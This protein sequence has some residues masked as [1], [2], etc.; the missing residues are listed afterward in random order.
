MKFKPNEI[1][2]KYPDIEDIAIRLD[3]SEKET[4]EKNRNRGNNTNLSEEG[5]AS[6]R[7][8]TFQYTAEH[9]IISQFYKDGSWEQT[10]CTAK[11]GR[12]NFLKDLAKLL[13][14]RNPDAI[15]IEIF[16]GK[17]CK[18]GAV[19]TKD[20][21]LSETGAQKGTNAGE[22]SAELGSLVKK[23]DEKLTETKE[24][25]DA[26]NLK[27]ELLRKDF[28]A[29]IKENE[30]KSAIKDLGNEHQKE[31]NALQATIKEKDKYIE[32]LEADLNEYEGELSGFE[33]ESR[34]E[35]ALPF[36]ALIFSRVLVQAGENLLKQNPKILKIG[37]GLSEDEVKKIFETDAKKIESGQAAND[38]SSFSETTSEGD[39][40]GLDEKHA[41]GIKEMVDFFK[42]VSVTEFK[43]LYT[44]D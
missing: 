8:K 30:H 44:I 40:A 11:S 5:G 22:Q 28:D 14:T 29:Q 41:E 2:K 13:E 18:G 3:E 42:Q 35:K 27:I 10:P 26:S 6:K 36:S 17:T 15:K 9:E 37:L 32:E 21:Y 31:I 25:P 43:K 16:K 38:S 4:K 24:S 39:Y 34:K 19:Y 12:E 7:K 33:E 23:F 1:F 20:I